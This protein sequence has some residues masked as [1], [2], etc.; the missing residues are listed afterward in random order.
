MI[1]AH[2]F[3]ALCV[4]ATGIAY[5]GGPAAP[6]SQRVVS[7]GGSVTEIIYSLGQGSRLVADDASSSHPEAARQLPRVGYYR[8]V[9]LEGVVAQY[10]DLV[11]ASENAGPPK[12]L[13]R[14]GSLGVA[15][16]QVSDKPTL[17]S[18]YQRIDQIAQ[19]LQVPN[20]GAD[21]AARVRKD[22]ALAQAIASPSRRALVLV[23]RTGPLM[24]AGN[25]TAAAAVLGLAGLE[26]ALDTHSGYKPISAEGLLVLA[27]DM[28]IITDASAKASGGM[29][30]F[31]GSAGVGATPA[32]KE[33]RVVMMDDLLILGLGPRVG[34]AIRQLKEAAR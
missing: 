29:A 15:V 22:V 13:T 12:T 24:G 32:A 30:T 14:L 17:A 4:F 31:R 1:M 21:L 11:L 28:I 16:R 2:W 8:S 6:T 9:P 5:A 7:L 34:Q 25:D 26:N 20:E 3:M 23:N 19:A 33:G 10:P 18:L 27:P